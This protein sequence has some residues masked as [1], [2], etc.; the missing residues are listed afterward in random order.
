MT[1]YVI[2]KKLERPAKWGIGAVLSYSNEK[3]RTFKTKTFC[4][5]NRTNT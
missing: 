3:I 1:K 5:N 2:P 4:R